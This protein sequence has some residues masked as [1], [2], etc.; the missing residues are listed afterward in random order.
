VNSSTCQA[1]LERRTNCSFCQK[2][3]PSPRWFSPYPGRYTDW[4]IPAS[5]VEGRRQKQEL[6]NSTGLNIFILFLL[7]YYYYFLLTYLLTYLLQLTFHPVAVVLTV[8]QTTWS[9]N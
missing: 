3:I 5:G 7:P 2:S 1:V 6:T 4:A 9:D 8:V